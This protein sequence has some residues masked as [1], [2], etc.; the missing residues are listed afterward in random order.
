MRGR[1]KNWLW[2]EVLH[3]QQRANLCFYIGTSTR[4]RKSHVVAYLST[5]IVDY[6][7]WGEILPALST[8]DRQFWNPDGTSSLEIASD[9]KSSVL[10]LPF[11]KLKLAIVWWESRS[12]PS[13]NNMWNDYS[14]DDQIVSLRYLEWYGWRKEPFLNVTFHI[15]EFSENICSLNSSPWVEWAFIAAWG[16]LKGELDCCNAR[17]HEKGFTTRSNGWRH[18]IG[19]RNDIN[20]ESLIATRHRET[21]VIHYSETLI[22]LE[23]TFEPQLCIRASERN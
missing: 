19:K 16:K 1:R 3:D 11:V 8:T 5:E 10:I 6:R 2:I 18:R 22:I 4:I 14:S 23:I 7:Y 12:D 9:L 15:C 17:V 21:G 20:I 13:G